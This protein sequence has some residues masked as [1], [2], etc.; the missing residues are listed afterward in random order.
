MRI[1]LVCLL[2]QIVLFSCGLGQEKTD[3]IYLKNGDIRKGTIIENVLNDY[4]KLEMRDGSIFTI[5]YADI[6]KIT[7]EVKAPPAN[8]QSFT[9]QQPPKSSPGHVGTLSVGIKGG[10]NF[11][12][13]GGDDA[14]ELKTVM[15]FN[16]GAFL[17][18]D[19]LDQLVLQGELLYDQKGCKWDET[20]ATL[21][22][23]SWTLS[24]L[25]IVAL[26]KYVI[27]TQG[28]IKPVLYGGPS[29]GIL[30]SAKIHEE[31]SG[32]SLDEN[33]KDNIAGTD[34]SLVIGA[35]AMY[36]I[37]NGGLLFDI[38]YCIGL[39]NINKNSTDNNTNQVF[40]VNIGYAF[41]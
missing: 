20:G 23:R 18:Y 40:S 5:K 4:I 9:T 29:L 30:L 17:A 32:Q 2:I 21:P 22:T 28:D 31:G 3:V 16:G 36:K 27:P 24:Y 37:G 11:A 13:I 10:L 34:F 7:K 39:S 15:K 14:S 8:Q 26:A 25:D 19:I 38:R 1:L 12:T 33:I 41:M 35:G 6:Q